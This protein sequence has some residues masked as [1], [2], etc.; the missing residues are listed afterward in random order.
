MP[1]SGKT[2]RLGGQGRTINITVI[3]PDMFTGVTAEEVVLL[4]RVFK[5]MFPS[6][7]RAALV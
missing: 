4:G 5:N 3:I 7:I 2:S 6:L 1:G